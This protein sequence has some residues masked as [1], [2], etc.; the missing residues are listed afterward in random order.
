EYPRDACLHQ[1]FEVQA[2]RTPDAVAVAFGEATV[3]YGALERRANQLAHSLR[4][5]RVGSGVRVGIC[6]ERSISMV[7]G[8]LGI[9]K[10]GGAY[11]PLD[12]RYP[13]QRLR[14][15]IADAAPAVVIVDRVGAAAL[16]ATLGVRQIALDAPELLSR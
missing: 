7:V 10:A 12:P 1:L 4:D 14:D 3:T 8:L 2:Q 16:G 11:V 13:L 5:E 6:V 9:L 15:I